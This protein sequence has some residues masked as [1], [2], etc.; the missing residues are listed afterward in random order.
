MSNK[1]RDVDREEKASRVLV[2]RRDA[3]SGD[4]SVPSPAGCG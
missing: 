3:R 4:V 1:N 2:V